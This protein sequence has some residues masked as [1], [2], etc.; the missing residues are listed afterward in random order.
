MS[1]ASMLNKTCDVELCLREEDKT[2]GEEKYIWTAQHLG[3]KCRLRNRTYA[4]RISSDAR[5]QHA[6][7]ALYLEYLKIDPLKAR[8]YIDE[9]YYKVTGAVDMGGGEDYLCL[10]LELSK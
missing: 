7:Y 2:T 8:V 5:Y 6:G 10:Y 4:E 3:V 1:F 9:Q